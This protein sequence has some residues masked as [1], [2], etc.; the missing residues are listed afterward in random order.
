M[1]GFCVQQ[2]HANAVTGVANITS[3]AFTDVFNSA[4]FDLIRKKGIGDGR[5]RSA[6]K[7]SPR[8]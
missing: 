8:V 7:S 4:F 6:D 1:V 2:L 5:A 3:Y